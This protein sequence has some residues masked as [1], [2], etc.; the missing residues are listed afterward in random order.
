MQLTQDQKLA[1]KIC[2]DKV[3]PIKLALTAQH[4]ALS[5]QLQQLQQRQLEHQRELERQTQH[6]MGGAMRLKGASS[7][8]PNGG[9]AAA[10]QGTAALQA[11]KPPNGLLQGGQQQRGSVPAQTRQQTAQQARQPAEA[12]ERE[13][14]EFCRALLGTELQGRGDAFAVQ[15]PPTGGAAA[16]AAA[17]PAPGST[18]AAAAQM[19]SSGASTDADMQDE[20]MA[21]LVRGGSGSQ[22]GDGGVGQQ[23]VADQLQQQQQQS[24]AARLAPLQQ[25]QEGPQF[26]PFGPAVA[27]AASDADQGMWTGGMAHAFR[28]CVEDMAVDGQQQ[29]QQ[30]QYNNS[31]GA[32]AQQASAG[33]AAAQQASAG[34]AVPLPAEQGLPHAAMMQRVLSTPDA[35]AQRDLLLLQVNS[36]EQAAL[37]QQLDRITS[38]LKMQQYCM[39]TYV[40]NIVSK[41]QMARKFVFCHPWFPESLSMCEALDDAGW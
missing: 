23:M 15:P 12:P 4:E 9:T 5:A 17:A 38:Q 33:G 31:G 27:A 30:Q 1:L 36:G 6:I 11:Q 3:K 18:A 22:A 29:W 37:E 7:R 32:A 25:Q 41:E 10:R 16:A 19:H 35:D 26:A 21:W 8:L 39:H 2:W 14:L 34:G 28:A 13:L 24:Y 20:G 40:L